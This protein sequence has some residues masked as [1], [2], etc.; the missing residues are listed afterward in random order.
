[1][2]SHP[3][4]TA[5]AVILLT[6]CIAVLVP[7]FLN[8]HTV[9]PT[10]ETKSAFLKNYTPRPVVVPFECKQF[11]SEWSAHQTAAAGEDFATHQRGFQGKIA[12]RPEG[13]MSL[14][15]ALRDDVSTQLVHDGAQILNQT[16]DPRIGF[17]VDYKLGRSYGAVTISPLEIYKSPNVPEGSVA[18]VLDIAYF[19]RWFPK[20]P[21]M[22]ALKINSE[23]D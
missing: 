16:G 19:E 21:G 11:K 14:M 5:L 2:K 8:R 1:M 17:H 12:I 6:V 4:V 3:I 9:Y 22:I 7:A 15:T 13:W 10:P 23:T 18:V 20:E